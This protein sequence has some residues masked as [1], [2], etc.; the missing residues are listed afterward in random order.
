MTKVGYYLA[1]TMIASFAVRGVSHATRRSTSSAIQ[2]FGVDKRYSESVV[3]NGMVHTAGQVGGGA[4]IGE[5]T[6][7]ALAD[8]D[9]A[10]ALAGVD[11]S[12]LVS[13][14]IYL[15]NISDYDGMN[16][17]YDQWVVPGHPPAR[18]TVQALLAKPEWLVEVTG[19]AAM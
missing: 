8:L 7:A 6:K 19:V 4:N 5:A 17:I 10:L 9:A 15:K 1:Y 12:K 14:T 11:K 13:M 16:E 2:R 18:A 3:A